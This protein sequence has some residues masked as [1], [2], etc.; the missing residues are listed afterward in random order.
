MARS[1]WN[2][3]ELQ[4]CGGGAGGDPRVHSHDQLPFR[5]PGDRVGKALGVL[6]QC[7]DVFSFVS[8]CLAW[9]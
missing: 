4:G 2:R 8:A 6:G 9:L 7:V 1:K 3:V 5:P